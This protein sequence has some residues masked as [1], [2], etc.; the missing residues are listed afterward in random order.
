MSQVLSEYDFILVLDASGSMSTED[1]GGRS[2]W[3]Y[4]QESVESFARDVVTFD[5]DGIDIVVFGGADVDLHQCVTADKVEEIFRN[6]APRGGTPLAEALQT[7]LKAAGRSDKKDFILVFTDGWPNNE[8]EAARTIIEASKKLEKDEDLTFLFVQV[9]H[10]REAATYLRGLDDSLKGAKFD[11]VDAKTM[12]EAEKFAS[13]A[14][15]VIAA[16]ND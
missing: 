8:A 5:D 2:R 7:A 1:C 10:S 12:E 13:T 16:I 4:M 6:R 15:L 9:G 14:D 3:K 11:I